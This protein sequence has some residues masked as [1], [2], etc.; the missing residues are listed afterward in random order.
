MKFLTV[1]YFIVICLHVACRASRRDKKK[2]ESKSSHQQPVKGSPQ[3]DKKQLIP[4]PP[5]PPTA[6]SNM[7]DKVD[8]K[9]YPLYLVI[10]HTTMLT[11]C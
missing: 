7:A 5:S 10:T 11:G 9:V 2:L 8:F 4:L 3:M 1:L 6:A